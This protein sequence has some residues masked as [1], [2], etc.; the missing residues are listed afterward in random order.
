MGSSFLTAIHLGLTSYCITHLLKNIIQFGLPNHPVRFTLYL[1]LLSVTAFFGLEAA[2]DLN[3]VNPF[4]YMHWRELPIIVLGLG[5]LVQI[6]SMAVQFTL[7][8]QKIFSRI[9][10]I[11]AL[12]FFMIFKDKA[13][14]FFV[15]CFFIAVLYLVIF[16][17]KNRYQKRAFLKMCFFLGIFGILKIPNNYTLYIFSELFL[18]PSLFYLFIFENSFGIS[19]LVQDQKT[20]LGVSA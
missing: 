16:V 2:A 7:I 6:I 13:L 20:D 11:G 15:L 12:L 18:F 14:V 19:A 1:I 9:P 10:F 4:F 3:L 8:Q 17:G 5:I